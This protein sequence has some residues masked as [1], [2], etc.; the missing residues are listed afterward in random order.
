MARRGRR[1]RAES[2]TVL[3][4]GEAGAAASAPGADDF[5][6]NVYCVLGMPIDA[7]DM[8]KAVGRIEAAAKSEAPFLISTPN[9][10]FLVNSRLDPEFRESILN[11]DLCPA[12]GMPI[13]W[14]ARLIG[15]PIKT[16]V[17]GSDI[18]EALKD[19]DRCTRRLSV[20]LFGGTEGVAAAAARTLNGVP[21]GLSCVG[22]IDPGFGAVDEMSS[23][24]VIAT[25]NASGADF[26]AVSL[27]AKKG[28]LWLQRNHQRLTIPVRVHL[29][30][31]VNFQAGTVKRAPPSVRK[32]GL[33]WLWRIK[34]E[35][36]LWRR[37]WNDGCVL[38]RLLLTRVLP[39]AIATRWYRLR[40]QHQAQDLL[41]ETTQDHQSTT[42]GLRGVATEKH[43]GKA[44]SRFGEV[45]AKKQKIIIV[46]LSDTRVI[47]ARFFGLLLTLRKQLK[48]QGAK[49][50]FTG[51][52]RRIERMFRLNELGFLLTP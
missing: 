19:P 35:P 23:D 18:F 44:I 37:Y 25:V 2:L 8:A 26:L 45:L 11:S 12:D 13:V 22:T 24:D 32:W 9:L 52:S 6:R 20:F 38:L 4:A 15:A 31:A 39:L 30:A 51:A 28:Q 42:I 46:D 7:I 29:G 41:V 1:G 27:G 33:E 43:V 10:N 21:A 17:A 34:E 3:E 14:I 50:I 40:W 5:Q 49:L 47:D 16:R 36:H 48:G